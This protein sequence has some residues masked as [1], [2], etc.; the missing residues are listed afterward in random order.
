M[1]IDL[2]LV[3]A[4]IIGFAVWMYILLDGFDLGI[5][6][7]FPFA[8]TRERKDVM[9]N[10]IAPVWD[11]NE[12]W[13]VLG[14]AGLFAA[15]PKAYAM[16]LPALYLPLMLFLFG[17]ILRGISFEF[18][19]KEEKRQY[20]WDWSFSGGAMLA[21]FMQGIVVGRFIEGF[22][23]VEGVYSGRSFDWLTP[24]SIMSGVGLMAGYA[25]LGATWLFMKTAGELQE[26]CRLTALK[27]MF[28]VLG[29][30]AL[31]SIWTPLEQFAIAQRW[32]AYP[33]ILYFAPV[34]VHTAGLALI[35]FIAL[36]RKYEYLPFVC[37][38]G[39]FFLSYTGL[40]ISLWPYIVPRVMTIWEA[41]SPPESQ[42]FVLTGV[43]LLIPLVFAYTVHNY[44]VF[45]GKVETE[46]GYH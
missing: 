3:W 4:A 18:R 31:V 14:G 9:M 11:G 6:I 2:P 16:I 34:P 33:N 10:S 26:W 37:S 30:I 29:F 27:L 24:F 22:P 28:V 17:L 23:I 40:G 21:T 42:L 25:L 35:L 39:L 19:F 20:L 38:T 12:T 8:K 43:L 41:A 44:W 13:L 15:F 1:T 46:G 45:R 7:L 36:R 5:G 32:F